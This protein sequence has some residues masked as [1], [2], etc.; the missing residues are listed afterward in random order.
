MVRMGPRRGTTIQ[1]DAWSLLILV[2]T[3]LFTFALIP[4]LIRTLQ[5]RRAEHISA[6]FLVLVLVASACNLVYFTFRE[7]YIA[8]SGFVANLIVWGIVLYYRIWPGDPR[9][10]HPTEFL[11]A[12]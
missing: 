12:K 6:S 7:E 11:Q 5:L 8:A 4:Q 10:D 9:T 1:F 2:G 3:L